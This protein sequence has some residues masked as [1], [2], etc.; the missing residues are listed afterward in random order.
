MVIAQKHVGDT[1]GATGLSPGQRV[2]N[3]YDYDYSYWPKLFLGVSKEV[4]ST[5]HFLETK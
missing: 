5:K 2:N 3:F 4:C 1:I